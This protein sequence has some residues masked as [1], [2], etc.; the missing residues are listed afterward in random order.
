M[1]NKENKKKYAKPKPASSHTYE[2][3]PSDGE[4]IV[5][6]SSYNGYDNDS[7]KEDQDG[8]IDNLEIGAHYKKPFFTNAENKSCPNGWIAVNVLQPNEDVLGRY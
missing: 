1:S 5:P 7:D 8:Y 6:E 4:Y 3:S 2:F